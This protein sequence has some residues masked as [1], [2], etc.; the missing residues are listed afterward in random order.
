MAVAEKYCEEVKKYLWVSKWCILFGNDR[1]TIEDGNYSRRQIRCLCFFKL[2]TLEVR[3]KI[4]FS[5]RKDQEKYFEEVSLS[6]KMV[7]VVRQCP[8]YH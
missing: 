6:V 3:H 2:I 8:Y 1:T 5:G 4:E 7:H